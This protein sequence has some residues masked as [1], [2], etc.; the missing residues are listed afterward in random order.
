MTNYTKVNI[1]NEG[2][3]ELHEKLMLTGAEVSVNQLPA[4]AGVPFVHAHRHNEEIY[5]I[6]SGHGTAV[7]D[8]VEVPLAAGDWLRLAPAAKRQFSAAADEGLRFICIQVKEN[9]L[10]AYTA[11]DA[12]IY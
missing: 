1:G 6:L 2:R 10:D 12:I 4:G 8:G 11:N 5:G 3:T 7:I 9:S